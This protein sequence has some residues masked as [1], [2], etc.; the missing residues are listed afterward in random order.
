M[1]IA[2]TFTLGLALVG[3]LAACDTFVEDVDIP[4]DR[5]A[6]DS[7][8]EQGSVVFLAT[9]VKEGFNDAYDVTALLSDLLSDA[10]QFNNCVSGSTFPTYGDIDRGEIRPDNN[11]VDGAYNAIS[12]YRYLADEL[13]RRAD[14]TITFSDDAEGAE[15]ERLARYT[16]LFHGGVARYFLAT[17]MA[18]NPTQG[19]APINRSAFIPS[20]ELYAEAIDLLDQ[21]K[22]FAASDYDER[23]VNSVIARIYLFQGDLDQAADF[24]ADGLADGPMDGDAP[25]FGRYASTSQNEWHAQG[26]IGRTQV[27][28]NARFADGDPRTPVVEADAA[29]SGCAALGPYYRQARYESADAAIPFITWQEMALIQAEAALEDGDEEGALGFAN[30]ARASYGL[31]ELEDFDQATLL[32]ERDK[33]LFTQGLRLIDQ[34]RFGL[35]FTYVV[36]QT[37]GTVAPL[38]GAWRYLPLTQSERNANTNL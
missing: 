37:A 32:S 10:G 24:A 25:Y 5:V 22:A 28:V 23:V 38:P 16:A 14:E 34:R 26:G 30:A 1:R 36:P 29:S 7:L 13:L 15:A 35:D 12:E 17:Y 2:F 19:G 21:S 31:D 9:G 18:L 20:S 4:I 6:S 8:D 33:T 11:S 3:S 27:T